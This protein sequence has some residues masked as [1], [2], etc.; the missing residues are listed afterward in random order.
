M[1]MI[2]G[3][4]STS[5]DVERKANSTKTWMTEKYRGRYIGLMR[6]EHHVREYIP[7]NVQVS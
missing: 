4:N 3:M 2:V 6:S 5:V 1:M 7:I